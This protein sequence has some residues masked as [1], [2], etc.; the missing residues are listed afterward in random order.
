MPGYC[1]LLLRLSSELAL[2][3]EDC[4]AR[5]LLGGKHHASVFTRIG[6]T[7]EKKPKK[8]SEVTNVG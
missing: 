8:G 2:I 3:A 7:G 1:T 4:Q 5:S 6:S